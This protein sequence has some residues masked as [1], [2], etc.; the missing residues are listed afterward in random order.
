LTWQKT[1]KRRSSLKP[2]S[3]RIKISAAIMVAGLF[4]SLSIAI[5]GY[6]FEQERRNTHLENIHVLLKA[7]F[8]QK[9]EQIANEIYAHQKE[10]LTLSLKELKKIENISYVIIYNTN[11]QVTVSTAPES[12]LLKRFAAID[13][14]AIDSAAEF[15]QIEYMDTHYADFFSPIEVI[16]VN[17]GY[18]RILY[19]LNAFDKESQMILLFFGILFLVLLVIV[20]FLNMF[21]NHCVIR[22][23][24]RLRNAMEKLQF[25]K[26]GVQVSIPSQD[27]IGQ[28]ASA[29]NK[30][31]QMLYEQEVELTD[32]ITTKETY[33]LELKKSNTALEQLN[34]N[35]ENRVQERTT[36]L[37]K[38]NLRLQAE[39]DERHRTYM[40]KR[41]LEKRLDRSKKMETLG[42]LAG[43]VAHDLNN[44]LSGIVSYPDLLLLDISPDHP[45]YNP[46]MTIKESGQK[47]AAI[48]QDLLTLARRGVVSNEI[49][50]LNAILSEYC[51]SPEHQKIMMFHS[52]IS[53]EMQLQ[54]NLLNIKGSSLHLKKTIMNLISNAAEAQPEGGQICISTYNRYVDTPIQGY[55]QIKEGEYAVLEVKDTGMGISEHDQEKIFEPFYTKKTMGRSGTGLGMA[56]VWGTI[57][58]HQGYIN[59]KSE[60]NQGTTFELFFPVTRETLIPKA[61]KTSLSA[62]MGHHETILIIDDAREQIEIATKILK[63]LNYKPVGMSSGE[64]AVTYL[65]SHRVDLLI[66]DMI[67]D[68]GMDGLDTYKKIIEIHPGQK[69]I[70]ASGYAENE[71]VKT[72]QELGAGPYIKKPYTIENL[73]QAIKIELLRQSIP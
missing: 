35:L 56:V 36:E 19:N 21:L 7:V 3:L 2:I 50:N 70:I 32:A 9:K 69:A 52:N 47:A 55:Q 64:A 51:A 20:V 39:M 61:E 4:I 17:V 67:M 68:P 53:V 22:P 29:F 73:G 63:K 12:D 15:T 13:L 44:V 60:L 6:P 33:A 5:L 31:S 25:A 57:Q 30:M 65:K 37:S 48:V 72:L 26:P 11:G 16:G 10:A 71:R 28:M 40:E 38:S 43:G 8:N 23:A 27:E 62:H 41:E 18:I 49:I 24:S 14:N 59:I 45:M 54:E 58:D 34:K 46:I 42:L 1:K 66:L